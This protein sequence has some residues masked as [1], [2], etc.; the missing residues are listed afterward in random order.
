MAADTVEGRYRD[1]LASGVTVQDLLNDQVVLMSPPAFVQQHCQQHEQPG[2][3]GGV[4]VGLGSQFGMDV[5]D[6]YN[7]FKMSQ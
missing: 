4:T 3:V 1:I 7:L 6:D 5:D 2:L